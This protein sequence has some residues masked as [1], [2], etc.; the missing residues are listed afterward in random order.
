[1]MV[2]AIIPHST[3]VPG[4]KMV[5]CGARDGSG[6]DMESILLFNAMVEP[7][8]IRAR[9]EDAARCPDGSTALAYRNGR[10]PRADRHQPAIIAA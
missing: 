1:M 7:P 5:D 6:C 3:S 2:N 10:A 4:E 8:E 9:R